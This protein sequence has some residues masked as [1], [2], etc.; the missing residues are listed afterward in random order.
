MYH[1]TKHNFVDWS[2]YEMYPLCRIEDVPITLRRV[3][4][5]INQLILQ[6]FCDGGDIRIIPHKRDFAIVFRYHGNL[7]YFRFSE[8]YPFAAPYLEINGHIAT[9][10]DWSPAFTIEKLA[11]YFVAKYPR[12][13]SLDTIN[14]DKSESDTTIVES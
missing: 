12:I 11:M 5:D 7:L 9:I 3:K 4:N 6:N 10:K 13:N 14:E 8:T 1:K 2:R